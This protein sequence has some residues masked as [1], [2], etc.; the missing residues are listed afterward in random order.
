[1]GSQGVVANIDEKGWGS[2]MQREQ[3]KT[4]D[5]S[6]IRE[7][8]QLVEMNELPRFSP[9]PARLLGLSAWTP[10]QRNASLVTAEY[11][12][13]WGALLDAFEKH[14]FSNLEDTISSLLK[15]HFPPNLL[16]HLGEQIYYSK[17]DKFFWD[18]FYHKIAE[19]LREY[20]TP[21]DTLVELGC[22]WGRNLFFAMSSGLCKNAFGG[23]YT[24]EG[25]RLGEL[26]AKTFR[27]PIEFAR[28]DYCNPCDEVL[29]RMR[30]AV[31]FTHNSIEQ[32]RNLPEKTINALIDN[33]PKAVVHF[34]PVYE[35]RGEGS[36]LHCL[37]KRY[38]EVNDYNRD[39]LTV[40]RKL[41]QQGRL[42]IELEKVHELG[43]NA[44]N[45][46]SFIVWIS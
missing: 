26:V 41:E 45:P 18:F 39:L 27:V 9:W 30:G 5:D 33:E 38:T 42:K 20:V 2:D 29:E 35:Y 43:L 31:I 25:I 28:F 40:L 34:E 13:K 46:G 16:F 12:E 19:V 3:T 22:G 6:V 24:E 14:R 4:E 36:L 8:F 37:W 11:G 23:E 21:S 1:L 10:R 44:F 17:S 15:S 7:R 32:I